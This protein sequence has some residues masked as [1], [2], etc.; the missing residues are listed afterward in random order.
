[1]ASV[2]DNSPQVYARCGKFAHGI[3]SAAVLVDCGVRV[4]EVV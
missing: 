1:M 2:A 3:S 4:G